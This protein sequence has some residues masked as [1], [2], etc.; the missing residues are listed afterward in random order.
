M[1]THIILVRHGET[2]WNREQVYRGTYDIPLNE[3]GRKQAGLASRALA[4][5]QIDAAYT[6]PLS[7]ATDT[8]AIVLKPHGVQAIPHDGFFDFDYGEWTGLAEDEVARRWP[9]EHRQW[10]STPHDIVIPGGDSLSVVFERAFGAMEEIVAQHPR[11]TVALF[12]HRVVNKLLVLGVQGLGLD[13]FPD[14]IQGNAC[15]NRFERMDSGYIVHS[16]NDIS[17]LRNE[18]VS[19]LETDF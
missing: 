4:K 3:N 10:I 17:H 2:A 13:K 1:S 16:L 15:I 19:L 9:D 12:A 6:S 11:K 5:Q 18:D 7:R 8:A 14:I